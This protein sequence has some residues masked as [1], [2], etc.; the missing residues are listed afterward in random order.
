MIPAIPFYFIRHGQTDWNH[1]G[2]FM[3]QQDIPLNQRGLIQAQEAAAYLRDHSI[4]AKRIVASP[5]L[6]A[7]RTAEIISDACG[8][9]LSFHDGLK[10]VY[11]G[12][13]EGSLKAYQDLHHSWINGDGPEG[14]ESWVAFKQRVTAAIIESLSHEKMTLI[15]AHGG[16]YAAIMDRLGHPNEDA[17][18]CVP[19]HFTPPLT[20]QQKWSILVLTDTIN[21]E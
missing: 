16:I 19:Y 7:R 21:N 14:A 2:R 18:N 5:L 20:P 1:E 9:P 8:I 13:A 11:F 4:Q 12:A 3:G 17:G 6:R 10:E 15:V